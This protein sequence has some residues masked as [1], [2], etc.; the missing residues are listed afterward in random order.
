MTRDDNVFPALLRYWR[1]TRGLSQLDLSGAS[2]VSAKHISFLE[3]AR[4]N[5]S[6]EMVLRLAATMDLPLRDQNA[7][8]VSAGFAA[9]F[10]EDPPDFD[11][12]VRR[13]L[14]HMM[15]H[16]EPFPLLV[17]DRHYDLVMANEATHR[18]LG[19]LLGDAAGRESN[20]MKLLFD[21]ELLRPFVVGWER[22]AR[23]MLLRLQRESLHRRR[24]AGLTAL[25]SAL[26]AYP[27]VPEDW[28][29]PDL[30]APSHATLEV[31]FEHSGQRF[32]FLT[33]L[34]VFQAPQNVSL[35]ELRIESYYPLDDATERLCRSLSGLASA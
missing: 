6:Q 21:P 30:T 5:P 1:G 11:P 22:I 17:V 8:L 13:A 4:A 16:Q 31:Q 2:G 14:E 20:V 29:A 23:A 28:R 7:L 19:F 10:E 25:A 15:R 27:G 3:T 26:C 18:L 24:D 9:M 34:T 33:A 35:E 32:G 12:A